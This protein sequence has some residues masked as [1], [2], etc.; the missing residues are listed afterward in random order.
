MVEAGLSEP[1]IQLLLLQPAYTSLAYLT[2]PYVMQHGYTV[3]HTGMASLSLGDRPVRS[4]GKMHKML[5]KLG[6]LIGECL[7]PKIQRL[8]RR[9]SVLDDQGVF[10]WVSKKLVSRFVWESYES[11]ASS[12]QSFFLD[13]HFL[14]V[15]F[16]S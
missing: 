9:V 8:S 3:L 4:G 13:V 7:F 1:R 12:G 2:A 10:R 11:R 15:R 5:A 6:R 14:D 16:L